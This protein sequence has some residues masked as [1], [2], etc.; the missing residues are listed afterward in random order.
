M[1][2]FLELYLFIS[3]LFYK[4]LFSQFLIKYFLSIVF[5]SVTLFLTYFIYI[6]I[7]QYFFLVDLSIY[8]IF[9]IYIFFFIVC[10]SNLYMWI[11]LWFVVLV[12]VSEEGVKPKAHMFFFVLYLLEQH[13]TYFCFFHGSSQLFKK[14]HCNIQFNWIAGKLICD[15]RVS[16]TCIYFNI[17]TINYHSLAFCSQD[18]LWSLLDFSV[19]LQL[20]CVI[21]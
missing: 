18:M 21:I 1:L 16:M 11:S 20:C 8:N 17:K 13:S 19:A 12:F 4:Y 14:L 6:Y 15:R 3:S 5:F 7:P 2:I 10:I 9:H